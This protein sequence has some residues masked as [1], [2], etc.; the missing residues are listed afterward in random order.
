MTAAVILYQRGASW[1]GGSPLGEQEAVREHIGNLLEFNR[2]GIVES[3]GAF[4]RPEDLVDSELVGLVV[5]RDVAGA[6]EV[7]AHDPAVAQGVLAGTVL[8]WH[9]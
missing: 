5:C 2:K 3:G 8:P 7:V 9:R 1:R 4:H 6:E